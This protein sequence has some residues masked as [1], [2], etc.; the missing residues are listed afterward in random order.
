ML[1]AN[2]KKTESE[3]MRRFILC[4]LREAKSCPQITQIPQI[5]IKP[6]K[7]RAGSG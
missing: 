5:Q 4:F 2:S 7:S 1:A 6:A 3:K